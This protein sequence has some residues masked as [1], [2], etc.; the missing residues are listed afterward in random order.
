MRFEN[1]IL[2]HTNDL[3]LILADFTLRDD[4]RFSAGFDEI[5]PYNHSATTGNYDWLVEYYR[6]YVQYGLDDAT[7]GELCLEHDLSPSGLAEFFADNELHG[8]WDMSAKDTSLYPEIVS[9]DSFDVAFESLGGGQLDPRGE[10]TTP[11]DS[12]FYDLLM[13]LWD[14]YHLSFLDDE[15]KE[16]YDRLLEL[17]A[18]YT[19]DFTYRWIKAFCEQHKDQIIQRM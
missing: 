9:L 10:S 18:P 19:S 12:G 16:K 11:I 5:G 7:V 15:G 13:S 1:I 6:D 8:Y 17:A 3:N 4:G 2:G 14:D